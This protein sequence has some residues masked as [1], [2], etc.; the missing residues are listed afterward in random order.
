M[1]LGFV[2]ALKRG[3]LDDQ[4]EVSLHG[5]FLSRVFGDA[6][7]Y[8]TVT[9]AGADGWELEAERRMGAGGKSVD[10]ALGF[11]RQ[12]EAGRVVVPIE[13]KS[14]RQD[15]DRSG[16]RALTPVQQAWDYANHS[17]GCRFIIVSNYKE[18]RLYSTA[19]TPD[20]CET[21]MLEELAD[22]RGFQAIL[23]SPRARSAARGRARRSRR[24]S[25]CC[26]PR[27]PRPRKRSRDAALP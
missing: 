23:L 7:G 19:R 12:G 4:K 21:F 18:T 13:L 27:R 10:G 17:P 25:S 24:P 15:L 6:L 26:S 11:F 20:V 16:G 5:D 14:V 1:L 8:R 9:Q 22:R 3:R 2:D